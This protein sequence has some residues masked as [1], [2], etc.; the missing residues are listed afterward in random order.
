MRLVL[1]LALLFM[2]FAASCSSPTIGPRAVTNLEIASAVG[3]ARDA[4]HWWSQDLTVQTYPKADPREL[5]RLRARCD[6]LRASADKLAERL[7][8][9][10][11]FAPGASDENLD[12]LAAWAREVDDQRIDLRRELAALQ[13]SL[14]MRSPED[15]ALREHRVAP[16]SLRDR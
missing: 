7:D 6:I 5:A 14:G 2:V 13:V 11:M 16:A 1:P 3:S 15:L 4:A 10:D 12:D 9:Q 8:E